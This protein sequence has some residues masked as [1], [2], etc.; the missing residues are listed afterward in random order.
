MLLCCNLPVCFARCQEKI[1][2]EKSPPWGVKGR[3]R[4]R[5]G[6]ELGLESG[7]GGFFPGGFFSRTVSHNIGSALLNSNP[8]FSNKK[9][10]TLFKLG[11]TF[12][13]NFLPAIKVVR[14]QKAFPLSER[15]FLAIFLFLPFIQNYWFHGHYC[16]FAKS[17]IFWVFKNCVCV[18]K[19]YLQNFSH[20]IALKRN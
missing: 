2:P 18:F 6:I 10:L 9:S 3:V 11:V 5:L 4:V 19:L 12:I 1:P 16:T 17:N 8:W 20:S 13:S 15:G 7:G 14:R